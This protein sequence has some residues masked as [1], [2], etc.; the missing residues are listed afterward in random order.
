MNDDYKE[1][2]EII[3]S[4]FFLFVLIGFQIAFLNFFYWGFNIILILILFLVIFKNF[5]GALF[6]GWFGGFLID[7]VHFSNFGISSLV[8]LLLTVF[9]IIFQKKALVTAKI[10]GILIIGIAAVFF[11]HFLEWAVNSVFVS[12][13]EKISFYLLNT[14]I[15]AELLF[16]SILLSVFFHFIGVFSSIITVRSKNHK[17]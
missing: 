17:L 11:Y 5:Y 7:T 10:G 9:L 1:I 13:Q 4:V 2:I 3:F 15:I 6:L 12:G 14:G 16:T 8:L